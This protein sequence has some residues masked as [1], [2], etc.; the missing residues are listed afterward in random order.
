MPLWN[1]GARRSR[2]LCTIALLLASSAGADLPLEE[3]GRV[4]TIDTPYSP[5]WVFVGDALGERTAIV[6]L[7]DGRMLGTMDSGFG[8]PQT[9]HPTRRSEIYA[10]ETHYSRGSRGE[11]SDVLTIYDKGSLA[12][13]A[14]VLLPP[15]RAISATPVAHAALSDDDRFAAI[16]NLTPAT[17]LSIV[18]LEQRR[19]VGEIQTPGCSLAYPVGTRRFAMLC[20]NGGLLVVR[21]D[22]SG[23]EAG[24]QRSE[25]FFDP[26]QDPVTEKAVRFGD[27]WLFPSYDGWVHPV[28]FSGA[29]PVFGER[30]SLTSDREREDGWKIGGF[31]HL[32]LHEPS[33][34]LYALMHTGG[35]DSHKQPGSE[36]WFFDLAEHKRSRR[37]ELVNPGFTYLGV[38]IEGGPTWGWLLD[39]FADRIMQAV[40]EIGVDSIAVTPDDAPR[41]LTSGM[42]SGGIAT[43]DALTGEFIGRVFSGNMTNVVLQTALPASAGQP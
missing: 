17:S 21:I 14:E 28:D 29:E 42:F 40:P 26:G 15:K 3:V 32:A 10:I 2:W 30:W 37:I 5:H 8:I 9:L 7:D 16:F 22:D 19:F 35:I 33:G 23:R 4:A 34:T 36:V 38:P 13:V 18:D 6:D 39:W 12:P 24:K 31:Q 27:T 1:R 41:L 43:F 11:R 20:M 25:P